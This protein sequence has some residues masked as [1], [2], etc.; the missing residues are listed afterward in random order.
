MKKRF[1]EDFD[2]EE[3]EED[4]NYSPTS[5]DRHYGESDED[6]NDRMQDQED[7]VDYYND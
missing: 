4:D 7:L 3:F 6:Y 5:W 1:K 2:E